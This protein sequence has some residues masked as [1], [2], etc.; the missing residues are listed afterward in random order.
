MKSS[1]RSDLTTPEGQESHI[2][3]EGKTKFRKSYVIQKNFACFLEQLF[4]RNI[5]K[6]LKKKRGGGWGELSRSKVH[7]ILH[8]IIPS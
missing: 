4:L 5:R 6:C 8:I 1:Q 2:V 3:K 7:E